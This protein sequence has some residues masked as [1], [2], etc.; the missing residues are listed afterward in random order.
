MSMHIID[1]GVLVEWGDVAGLAIVT[2][3]FATSRAPHSAHV[4]IRVR[5]AVR[6][7]V[8]KRDPSHIYAERLKQSL[9]IS[10]A[11]PGNQSIG[12]NLVRPIVRRR[13]VGSPVLDRQQYSFARGHGGILPHSLTVPAG[14]HSMRVDGEGLVGPAVINTE[15][16]NTSISRIT[17][18]TEIRFTNF[19]H[20]HLWNIPFTYGVPIP[21][22]LAGRPEDIALLDTKG[23][24]VPVSAQ[25]MARGLTAVSAGALLDFAGDFA[26][27]EEVR[28][29]NWPSARTLRRLRRISRDRSG[30]RRRDHRL[31]WPDRG[32]IPQRPL[33]HLRL[34]SRRRNRSRHPGC[35]CDV[36]CVVASRKIFRASYDPA[37]RLSLEDVTPIAPWSVLSVFFPATASV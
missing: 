37:P 33:S 14:N 22:G 10:Y 24:P 32:D 4:A 23:N 13:T 7:V 18:R 17:V 8:V 9:V 19:Y 12:D 27:N 35:R 29:G 26:P 15:P 31:Q 5:R 30:N 11:K 3:L 6:L 36:V 20:R 1:G 25:P 2:S 34:A 16:S 21:E 28:P